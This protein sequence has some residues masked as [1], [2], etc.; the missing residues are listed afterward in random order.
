MCRCEKSGL[1]A[2]VSWYIVEKSAVFGLQ[3]PEKGIMHQCQFVSGM[4]IRASG[5]W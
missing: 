2:V 4:E 5:W 3:G 1:Q